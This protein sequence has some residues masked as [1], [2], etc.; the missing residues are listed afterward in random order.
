MY[1]KT[2]RFERETVLAK[3]LEEK[4]THMHTNSDK[5]FKKVWTGCVAIWTDGGDDDGY[6]ERV[7]VKSLG[8][9]VCVTHV[10]NLRAAKT[11]DL[12]R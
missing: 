2:G 6:K 12:C 7:K 4:N 1:A 9:P 5:K 10:R 8:G 11:N 3:Y